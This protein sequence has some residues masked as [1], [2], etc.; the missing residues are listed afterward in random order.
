[1]KKRIRFVKSFPLEFPM[2][3]GDLFEERPRNGSPEAWVQHLLRYWSGQFV[4]GERG[5]R[6]LWAMVNNL[7]LSEAR[8][9][10]FGI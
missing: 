6:V 2:G 4:G 7:L 5:Q 9:R 10:G 3:I 8:S 1:M